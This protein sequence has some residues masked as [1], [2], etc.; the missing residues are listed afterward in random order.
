MDIELVATTSSLSEQFH[1]NQPV[2]ISTP[3]KPKKASPEQDNKGKINEIEQS[4][5]Y[6]IVNYFNLI[7]I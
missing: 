6:F 7:N 5:Y 3:S 2:V 4:R 1:E